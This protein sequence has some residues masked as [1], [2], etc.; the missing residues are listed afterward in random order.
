MSQV[1]TQ[2]LIKFIFRV[3]TKHHLFSKTSAFPI[4]LK[5]KI[6]TKPSFRISSKIQLHN[7][8]KTSAAKCWTNSIFKILTSPCAQSLNKRLVLCPNVS[9]QINKLLPTWSSASKSATVT[10]SASFKLASSHL[11]VKFTKQELVSQVASGPHP[12]RRARSLSRKLV[13]D[14]HLWMKHPA[15]RSQLRKFQIWM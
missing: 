11:R 6:L 4:N 14:V 15:L 8:Y 13:P 10:T 2:I 9:S 7:L 3:L 1:Q 12:M 5:I